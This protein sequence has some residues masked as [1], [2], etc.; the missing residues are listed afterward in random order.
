MRHLISAEME[1]EDKED[2]GQLV[3]EL[4]TGAGYVVLNDYMSSSNV[5][6]DTVRDAFELA[7]ADTMD[8]RSPHPAALEGA[9]V[10]SASTTPTASLPSAP[11]R[12]WNLL[13]KNRVLFDLPQPKVG[14]N[15]DKVL[16]QFLGRG[17]LLAGCFSNTIFPGRLVGSWHQDYPYNVLSRLG[18]DENACDSPE[19]CRTNKLELTTILALD[20]FTLENGA[21]WVVPGSQTR[22]LKDSSKFE[23]DAVQ[24]TCT[25]GSLIILNGACMHRSGANNTTVTDDASKAGCKC[26]RAILTMYLGSSVRPNIDPWTSIS[27]SVQ[28]SC[29]KRSRQLLGAHWHEFKSS[30]L[31]K[32]RKYEDLNSVNNRDGRDSKNVL[33]KQKS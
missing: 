18:E 27:S 10:S 29:S 19:I 9:G 8:Q 21:T 22:L 25:A 3:A 32:K 6:L 33:Q 14:S 5:S 4:A 17:Y 7:V 13:D 11:K 15:L 30:Q 26:R 23:N 20:D 12:I 16:Q 31:A 1:T 2:I 24:I 28:R